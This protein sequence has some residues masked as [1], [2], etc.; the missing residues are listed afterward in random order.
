MSLRERRASEAVEVNNGRPLGPTSRDL[1]FSSS[2]RRRRRM[3]SSSRSSAAAEEEERDEVAS[4]LPSDL[5]L[6]FLALV[7]EDFVVLVE[8]KAVVVGYRVS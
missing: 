1:S 5:D 4:P 3:S 7:R 8:N 6:A 2:A